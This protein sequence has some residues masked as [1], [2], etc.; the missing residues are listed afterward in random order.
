MTAS[1]GRHASLE[2]VYALMLEQ[3][4]KLDELSRLLVDQ[5]AEFVAVAVWAQRNAHVDNRLNNLEKDVEDLRTDARSAATDLRAAVK[6][7]RTETSS[8][9]PQWTAVGSFVVAGAA[10]LIAFVQSIGGGG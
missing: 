5:R 2:T 1:D 6:E 3:G 8:R 10:L 9:R 4:K 7:L